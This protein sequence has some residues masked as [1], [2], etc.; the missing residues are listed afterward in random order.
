MI[1]S[2]SR[3]TSLRSQL[4]D[5]THHDDVGVG[6]ADQGSRPASM[7]KAMKEAVTDARKRAL[8]NFGNLLGLCIYDKEHVKAF[9]KTAT[10][11]YG[12]DVRSLVP[13]CCAVNA[14]VGVGGSE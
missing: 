10:L 14:V 9:K 8:K 4:K 5:G 12:K 7:Q 6:T 2:F 11:S 13:L 3:F 1:D